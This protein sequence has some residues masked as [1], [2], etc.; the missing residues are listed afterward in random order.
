MGGLSDKEA[1]ELR[2][3]ENYMRE[4]LKPMEAARYFERMIRDHAHTEADLGALID[5]SESFVSNHLRVLR[6]PFLCEQVETRFLTFSAALELLGTRPDPASQPWEYDQWKRT[7]GAKS[8][9]DNGLSS[10]EIRQ[11]KKASTVTGEKAGALEE[12]HESAKGDAVLSNAT[13]VPIISEASALSESFEPSGVV[14]LPEVMPP[15]SLSISKSTDQ[16]TNARE[17]SSSI[18]LT[19]RS[20]EILKLSKGLRVMLAAFRAGK[21]VTISACDVKSLVYVPED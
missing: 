17:G 10:K 8:S 11:L 20:D 1:D 5:R 6:E 19:G 15:S 12:R 14:L 2:L 4:D 7:F 21:A 13:S 16:A 3:A 18:T 9:S